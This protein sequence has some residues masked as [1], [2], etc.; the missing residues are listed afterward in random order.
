MNAQIEELTPR[1]YKKGDQSYSRH[2]ATY[3]IE[4]PLDVV[5][6][7]YISLA[8]EVVWTGNMIK[9]KELYDRKNKLKIK[10]GDPFSDPMGQ[11]QLILLDLKILYGLVNITVGHEVMEVDDKQK[12]IQTSYLNNSKSEGSQYIKFKALNA[13]KTE[14]IHETFY[15]SDSRYRDKYIYPFFH[16]KALNEFHGNVK[17][18][19][20]KG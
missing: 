15:K 19:I 10:P 7:K 8:P 11:G 3:T 6:K 4:K 2:L 18:H 12:V 5:W 16:T 1:C 20:L 9:F 17:R 14:V 13:E